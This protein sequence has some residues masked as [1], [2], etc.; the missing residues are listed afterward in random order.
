MLCRSDPA[1][2]P[3][4]NWHDGLRGERTAI[5]PEFVPKS[6]RP[7]IQRRET[8]NVSGR[9][10]LISSPI[11]MGTGFGSSWRFKF[12]ASAA[13]PVTCSRRFGWQTDFLST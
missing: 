10:R 9:S 6:F 2:C 4:S 3:E 13:Q 1:R 5:Q 7:A 8:S 12:L 11:L